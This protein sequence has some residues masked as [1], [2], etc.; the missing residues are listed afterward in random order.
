MASA[1]QEVG[2][3]AS[4]IPY[5]ESILRRPTHGIQDWTL[6]GYIHPAARFKLAGLYADVGNP[7]KAREHYRIFLDTF[8][9]PDPDFRWMV[10]EARLGLD[11][12]DG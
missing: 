4:A 12:A 3:P 7:G 10:E 5:L 9:D 11:Q 1:H 6:Q 2:Q 8:T